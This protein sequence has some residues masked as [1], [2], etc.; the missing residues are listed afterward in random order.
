[1]ET[2]TLLVLFRRSLVS[3]TLETPMDS[4]QARQL[5]WVAMPSSRDSPHPGIKTMSLHVLH[6]RRFFTVD[7]TD[8]LWKH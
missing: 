6:V 8:M 7:T 2:D 1:M 3:N 4:I 5:E